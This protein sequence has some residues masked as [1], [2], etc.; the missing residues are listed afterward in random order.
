MNAQNI[1]KKPVIKRE[2]KNKIR[3]D[4]DRS[5]LKDRLKAKFLN[6]FFTNGL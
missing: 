5:P 3:V 4:F 6:N 1:D 2:S